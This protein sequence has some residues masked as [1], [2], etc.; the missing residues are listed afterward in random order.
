MT[1]TKKEI[2]KRIIAQRNTQSLNE[3]SKKSDALFERL[4]LLDEYK[5]AKIVLA[6]MDYKNEVMTGNFIKRCKYDG[7]RVALPKVENNRCKISVAGNKMSIYEINDVEKDTSPG[8]MGI[9]EPNADVLKKLDPLEIDFA[10]IPGVAFDCFR[11][12]IGYGAGFYDRFLSK[13]RADCVKVGV[14]YSLQLVDKIIVGKY[15]LPM[16]IVITEDS[17]IR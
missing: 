2:R 17:F 16:D 1:E 3:I 12:R 13:L 11:Q 4:C 5:D 6:Y 7:K 9:L 8:F 14:A 15:D 10:V